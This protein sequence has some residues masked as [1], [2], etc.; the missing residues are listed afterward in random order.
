MRQLLM[1]LRVRAT[2][3]PTSKANISEKKTDGFHQQDGG[4]RCHCRDL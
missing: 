1:R 2:E 3:L 4:D